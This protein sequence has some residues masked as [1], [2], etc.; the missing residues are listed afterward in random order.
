MVED[1]AEPPGLPLSVYQAVRRRHPTLPTIRVRKQTLTALSHA[2]ED[3]IAERCERPVLFG[4]FQQVQHLT[5][6]LPR[7]QELAGAAT[8]V[9]VFVEEP[10]AGPTV[11]NGVRVVNLPADAPMRWEWAVVADDQDFGFALSAWEIPGQE[12]T[13]DRDRVFEL[14]WSLEPDP[15]RVATQACARVAAHA[16]LPDAGKLV[17][18]TPIHD[19]DVRTSGAI[20]NRVLAR[21]DAAS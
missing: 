14:V 12:R 15:V 21:L 10:A 19:I 1:L 5:I 7:W 8:S 9:V 11:A 6:P 2:L 13:R 3:E 4:A 20:F 16:G 18:A 17:P